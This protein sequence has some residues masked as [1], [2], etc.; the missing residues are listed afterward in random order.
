[1]SS[2]KGVE[3]CSLAWTSTL[4]EEA[5]PSM[6][7]TAHARECDGVPTF[8]L[9]GPCDTPDMKHLSMVV[10]PNIISLKE[11]CA[12]KQ[13]YIFLADLGGGEARNSRLA[14]RGK[15]STGSTLDA[16]VKVDLTVQSS[17]SQLISFLTDA[18]ASVAVLTPAPY[19][20]IE[21]NRR[22]CWYQ[23]SVGE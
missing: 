23:T 20:Q 2:L 5:E 21:G 4:Y 1:L 15:S 6:S 18:Q 22:D 10:L 12:L 17:R 7:E 3:L 8:M 13:A 19:S 9:Y 11:M 14:V 16:R